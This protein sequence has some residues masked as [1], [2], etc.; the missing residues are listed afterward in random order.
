MALDDSGNIYVAWEGFTPS[1]SQQSIV[2]QRS[3]DQGATWARTDF[4]NGEHIGRIPR[5]IAI[6]HLGSVWLLWHSQDN[7]IAPFY[8]NLSRSSDNGRTFVT[9]FRS[10]AYANGLMH[11]KL[12][13]DRHGS[14]YV[15]W[16]DAQFKLTKFRHGNISDRTDAIVF[17][18]GFSINFH[19][20]LVVGSDFLVHCVWEGAFYDPSTGYHEYV[21]YSFSSD[22][23]QTLSGMTR[24]DT[25]DQVGSS[26]VHHFPSLATNTQGTVFVS[27]T[28]EIASNRRDIRFVRKAMGSLSF[29]EPQVVSDSSASASLLCTDF[30]EQGINIVGGDGTG[31]FH[32]RSTNSGVDFTQPAQLG[33][34]APLGLSA[35]QDGLLFASGERSLR[36]VFSKTDILASTP[37]VLPSFAPLL[38][39]YPNPFNSS[40]RISY[41]VSSVGHVLLKVIDILGREIITLS[42]GSQGPGAYTQ[43]WNPEQ[44]STGIFLVRLHISGTGVATKRIIFIK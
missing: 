34:I 8:L 23:G 28:R 19:P 5:D 26:Y 30:P 12:A 3:T 11:S 22:T 9:V 24:V 14:I 32:R 15:L 21:F 25:I 27:Y 7:E 17:H 42:N 40:V 2:I 16:D 36:I 44:L 37:L 4:V 41:Q 43:E 10:L 35:T 13:T 1:G 38:V 31:T 6:D 20:D 39:C 33:E 29:W 18:S